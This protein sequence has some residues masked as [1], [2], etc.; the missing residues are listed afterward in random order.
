VDTGKNNKARTLE[1]ASLVGGAIRLSGAV[2]SLDEEVLK[3]IKRSNISGDG[4]IQLAKDAS[5]I[6]ADSRA[7]IILALPGESYNSHFDTLRTII[8]ADFNHVNTYQLMMLPGTEND[9]PEIRKNFDIQ[10]GFRVLPRC[11]G[12]F[13]VLGKTI[14]A[15]EIEEICIGNNTMTF[16]DYVNC[17]KMHLLIHIFHNDELFHSA[18]KFI[19]SL[20]LPIFRWLE[21]IFETK[22]QG[23]VK[24]VF[25]LFEKDTKEEVN[26]SFSELE[27]SIDE[28]TVKR[29]VNGELGYNLLF[30]YK[31]IAIND[32]L[33]DFMEL[34]KNSIFL[35][36]KENGKDTSENLSFVE[37][38]LKFDMCRLTNVFSNI[39]HDP[40]I[41]ISHDILSF[42]EEK[43]ASQHYILE[44]AKTLKF[45]FSENQKD[46]IKRSLSLY[47]DNTIGISFLLSKV[48][49]KRL[50]REPIFTEL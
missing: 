24:T 21:I 16:E 15:A 10:T 22:S 17:R 14:V 30:V 26:K 36:L 8:N 33:I 2:Q 9:A 12:F 47:G 41:T 1:A 34:A 48:F 6:D 29:Y 25:D 3:N 20:D 32:Y 28:S 50:L 35:F 43:N 11:F 45:T 7:E 18:L 46:I 49:V 27:Q 39:D 23:N 42:I 31:T 4:L 44:K 19:K 40:T 37:S 5:T 38:C 13:N